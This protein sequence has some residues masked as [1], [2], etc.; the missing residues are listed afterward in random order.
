MEPELRADPRKSHDNLQYLLILTQ[1]DKSE[2]CQAQRALGS[3]RLSEKR[4]K[5]KTDIELSGGTSTKIM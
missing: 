4:M 2:R 1:R 3:V 5:A